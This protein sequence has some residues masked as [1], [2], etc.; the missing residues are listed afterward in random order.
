MCL[1]S[2]RS[3]CWPSGPANTRYAEISARLLPGAAVAAACRPHPSSPTAP[4]RLLSCYFHAIAWWLDYLG[5]PM[6]LCSASP[7]VESHW[8][9]LVLL[10]IAAVQMSSSG[11]GRTSTVLENGNWICGVCFTP[12]PPQLLAC[13]LFFS[14]PI[15]VAVPCVR[16]LCPQAIKSRLSKI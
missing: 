15:D 4:L 6:P 5:L 8:R 7:L 9:L 13:L 2:W 10:A 14:R 1:F 12:F 3:L 16:V 11:L